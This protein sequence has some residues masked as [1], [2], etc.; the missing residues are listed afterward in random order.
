[1][2]CFT[3]QNLNIMVG[4]TFPSHTFSVAPRF[5]FLNNQLQITA[6]AEGNYG[7][8]NRDD[9]KGWG[10]TY[11]NSKA[12]RLENDAI[13]V[14]NTQL[15]GSGNN[16]VRNLYNADFWTL[17]EVGARYTLPQSVIG[18]IGASRASLAVSA[19][20]LF[21]IWR[22]QTKVGG[23]QIVDPEYGDG[24]NLDGQGNFWSLP[25]LTSL[26]VTLR[27]TF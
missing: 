17:R 9:G 20:N 25:P 10:H 18:S 1:V 3:N 8:T 2:D 26:N 13:W 19:R 23:Q 5:S 12:S 11:N 16:W 22:A 15:N 24:R 4:Q 6:L 27:L 7:R 21:L 14:A